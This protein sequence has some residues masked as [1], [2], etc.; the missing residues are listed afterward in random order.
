MLNDPGSADGRP[1]D[2]YSLAKVLWVLATDQRWPIQ[3][4]QRA[5]NPQA[6]IA[7]QV[8]HPRV[9]ELDMLIDR[10]TRIDP[11][12][13]PSMRDMASALEMWM[14]PLPEKPKSAR[15][16]RLVDRLDIA[17]APER[18]AH[19]AEGRR[20]AMYRAIVDRIR[21]AVAPVFDTFHN[22]DG[23]SGHG[24]IV[25]DV[26]LLNDRMPGSRDN[27]QGVSIGTP[28]SPS[29]HLWF[30]FAVE[31]RPN[32]PARLGAAFELVELGMTQRVEELWF[33]SIDFL[34]G[35]PSEA[36]AAE[37]IG[38]EAQRNLD[39]VL[40]AFVNRVEGGPCVG[41]LRW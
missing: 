10:A 41:A 9:V 27:W 38:D 19:D 1:A 33:V 28:F 13:R 24:G 25:D 21:R 6:T 5:D 14:R 32:G 40:E 29:V 34:P 22:T 36:R 20:N 2:V 39:A 30:G 3:G 18:E 16:A 23:Y 17:T 35:D 12:S 15:V 4:E 26:N 11:T 37:Q 8:A 31:P 7:N